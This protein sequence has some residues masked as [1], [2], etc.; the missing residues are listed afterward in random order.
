[1]SVRRLQL[2][3]AWLAIILTAVSSLAFVGYSLALFGGS[4]ANGSNTFNTGTM[5][6]PT[7]PSANGS[8]ATIT[9]NWTATS[10]PYATGT[11]VLRSS[12]S[13]GPYSQVGQVTPAGTTSYIDAPISGTYY[14]VLRS[15]YQSWESA[16][17]SQVSA[18]ASTQTGYLDC[19]ANAAVTS[20]SGDNNGYQTNPGNACANGSGNASDASSG[21]GTST[22]CTATGKDR[23]IFYDYGIS[24]PTGSTINGIEVRTDA[25]ADS[26]SGIPRLCVQLSWNGGA[27]WTTNQTAPNLTTSETTNILGSTSDNWGRTWS[28]TELNNT[29]FRV[30]ITD[31]AASTAR[32]FSLDWVSVQVT[33]TP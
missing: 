8:L 3:I 13:G 22:S 1:M 11:R 2:G 26:K 17:S 24:I 15:Y 7:A 16:N 6:A 19:S 5:A 23:H 14:Y 10:T 18:A 4:L 32:T 29:N 20:G 30:R 31:V 28:A 33:Y 27:T 25:W 12:T 21:T 9:L